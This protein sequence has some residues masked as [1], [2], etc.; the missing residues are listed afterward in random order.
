MKVKNNVRKFRKL[1]GLS[2]EEL[3]SRIPITRP[4]LS[5]I[6]NGKYEPGIDVALKLSKELN[7]PVEAIF[8]KEHVQHANQN[9]A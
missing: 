1:L 6:E 3:A 5:D 9:T 7:Q 8:F 2:Q 4:Y